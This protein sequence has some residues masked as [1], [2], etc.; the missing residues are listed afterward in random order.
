[1]LQGIVQTE[2]LHITCLQSQQQ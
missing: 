1:M 2:M